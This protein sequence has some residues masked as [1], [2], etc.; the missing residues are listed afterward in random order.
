MMAL[1]AEIIFF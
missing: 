1:D